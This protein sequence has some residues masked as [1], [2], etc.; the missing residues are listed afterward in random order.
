MA[1]AQAGQL[2]SARGCGAPTIANRKEISDDP[3]RY[4]A[5]IS[6]QPTVQST[7]MGANGTALW[8]LAEHVVAP[9]DRRLWT[10]ASS[11]WP[12]IRP[13]W[14]PAGHRRLW[15]QPPMRDANFIP[16]QE[17]NAG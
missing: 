13:I 9:G 8:R 12:A 6:Q 3:L 11:L 17:P 7:A 5:T 10:R 15:I 1:D 2:C 16:R 4:P 14:R